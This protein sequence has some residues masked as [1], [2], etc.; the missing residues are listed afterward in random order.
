[1]RRRPQLRRYNLRLESSLTYEVRLANL[2]LTLQQA[3]R[4]PVPDIEA[5]LRTRIPPPQL[6][7]SLLH[8][9]RNDKELNQVVASA[10][11]L[12]SRRCWQ[13]VLNSLSS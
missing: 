12:A 11:S 10:S 13:K 3:Y 2:R 5:S 8:I 6:V 4:R 7:P 1:M 9:A